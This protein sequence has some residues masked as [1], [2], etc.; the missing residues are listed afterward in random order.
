MGHEQ[1]SARTF[2]SYVLISTFFSPGENA[3]VIVKG[4]NEMITKE[5]LTDASYVIKNARVVLCQLE[6]NIDVTLEALKMA[7]SSE[8]T[9]LKIGHNNS[10]VEIIVKI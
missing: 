9:L 5:D 2:D 3:I 6:I 7:K 1:N 4:A 8:G 10:F